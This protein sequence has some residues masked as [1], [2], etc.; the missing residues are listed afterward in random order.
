MRPSCNACLL[1]H[2]PQPH[3]ATPQ[4][5]HP[6]GAAA[7]RASRCEGDLRR[8]TPSCR[9]RRRRRRPSSTS[10][11]LTRPCALCWCAT[12][13]TPPT[14]RRTPRCGA[15][16]RAGR[17]G[18]HRPP[19]STAPPRASIARARPHALHLI[20][21]IC[22]RGC[23]GAGVARV[24][25]ARRGAAHRHPARL[26]GGALRLSHLAA[27]V[28]ALDGRF[29]AE[30]TPNLTQTQTQTLTRTLTLTQPNPNPNP[31]PNQERTLKA[32]FDDGT[33]ATAAVG[34][35]HAAA[36]ALRLRRDGPGLPRVAP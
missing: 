13:T 16:G 10:P 7:G 15:D 4:P 3:A 6:Q 24:L 17:R 33:V 29:F 25:P 36:G 23:T 11:R 9:R 34:A 31:N 5:R 21:I 30:R 27:A 2:R 32:E 28:D 20:C 12:C 35:R 19:A 26:R 18:A 22:S 14:R 8:P 1:T